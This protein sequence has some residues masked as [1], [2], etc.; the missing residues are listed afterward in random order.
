MAYL[1]KQNTISLE[2]HVF[3]TVPLLM[4]YGAWFSAH[5]RWLAFL[6]GFGSLLSVIC[7]FVRS[8][9][10]SGQDWHPRW[11]SRKWLFI[12]VVVSG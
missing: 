4:L 8:S 1:L 7:R 2:R 10:A 9:R 11:S 6:L 12:Y 5:P 3:A